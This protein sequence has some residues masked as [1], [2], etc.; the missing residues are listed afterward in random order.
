MDGEAAGARRS[1]SDSNL[2]QIKYENFLLA[3]SLRG[4]VTGS[5]GQS[6]N[7]ERG[8]RG[9]QGEHGE[10]GEDIKTTMFTT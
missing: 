4:V 10:R 6:L 9:E 3:T 8:K 1:V 7:R 5:S 2:L